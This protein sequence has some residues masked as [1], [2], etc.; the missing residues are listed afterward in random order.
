VAKLTTVRLLLAL[1]SIHNWHLHQ[2][3]VNN[4]FLHGE[5]QE[6]VYMQIPDGVHCDNP[7]QVC[8]L[9]KSLYGLKQT[10]RKWNERLTSLLLREGYVQSTA[11]YSLFTVTPILI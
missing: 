4:A 7:N 2:L 3:Y 8:K 5:L 6:D 1:S 10:S 9:Q 11:D